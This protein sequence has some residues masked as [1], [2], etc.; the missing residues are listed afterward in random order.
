MLKKKIFGI[1]AAGILAASTFAACG[2][3][4][5]KTEETTAAETT[6]LQSPE[7]LIHSRPQLLIL[8]R[9]LPQI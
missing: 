3:G 2:N 5:S 8:Q 6:R 4:G 1:A 7:A 9:L